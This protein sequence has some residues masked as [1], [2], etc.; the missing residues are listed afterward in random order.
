MYKHRTHVPKGY[1]VSS[2]KLTLGNIE[3]VPVSEEVSIVNIEAHRK[4]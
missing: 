2:E 4:E 1:C 3:V